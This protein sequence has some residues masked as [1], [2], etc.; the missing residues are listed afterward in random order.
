MKQPKP[1]KH[2]YCTMCDE[3]KPLLIPVSVIPGWPV[4]MWL[5]FCFDCRLQHYHNKRDAH[6][7]YNGESWKYSAY[8]SRRKAY[9]EWLITEYVNCNEKVPAQ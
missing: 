3:H 5:Y 8:K 9:R 4:V 2:D 1:K 6:F 7:N